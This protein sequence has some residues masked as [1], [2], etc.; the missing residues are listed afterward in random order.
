MPVNEHIVLQKILKYCNDA[1]K[2][3]QGCTYDDFI[4]NELYLT[5]SVFALSQLGELANRLDKAFYQ[6]YPEIPWNA[7]RGLRNHIVHEYEGIEFQSLWSTIQINIPVL[8]KQLEKLLLTDFP[9][10]SE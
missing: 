1:M 6:K 5:F 8:H 10:D 3:A 7:M 9:A 2:Y 4:N